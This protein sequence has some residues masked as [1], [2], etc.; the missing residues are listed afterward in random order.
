MSNSPPFTRAYGRGQ[1]IA[2]ITAANKRAQRSI[3]QVPTKQP[4]IATSA[5][6]IYCTAE[7]GK[8]SYAH[9]H[10]RGSQT[11][12]SYQEQQYSFQESDD[13]NINRWLISHGQRP[14]TQQSQ[15]GHKPRHARWTV[16]RSKDYEALKCRIKSV[17]A[18]Q[19]TG[20]EYVKNPDVRYGNQESQ[21]IDIIGGLTIQFDENHR[22]DYTI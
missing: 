3:V 11:D 15:T 9:K 7:Q 2:Q 16:M 22:R 21:T 4:E 6:M 13:D 5:T 14:L 19:N 12:I 8:R 17:R 20:P 10:S 18:P 1:R